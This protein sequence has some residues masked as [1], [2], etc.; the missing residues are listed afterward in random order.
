LPFIQHSYSVKDSRGA[1]A[2][3][4]GLSAPRKSLKGNVAL[5]FHG[6]NTGSNPVGDANN[7]A[8]RKE[9]RCPSCKKLLG[10]VWGREFSLEMACDR[11]RHS[12]YWPGTQHGASGGN[13]RL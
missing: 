1:F 11:F 3:Q 10:K 6:G 7:D 5:A 12:R 2:R 9:A 8:N 4:N 13:V